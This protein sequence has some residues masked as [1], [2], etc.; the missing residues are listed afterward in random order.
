MGIPF[1]DDKEFAS[2]LET[3]S[4]QQFDIIVDAIFGFGFKALPREPFYGILKVILEYILWQFLARTK[5][6][7]VSIDV[8]SGWDV[9]KGF[10]GVKEEIRIDPTV[11]VSLSAPKLCAKYFFGAHYLGGR[12]IPP[13]LN[14]NFG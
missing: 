9:E 7:I 1:L 14:Q 13:F 12:F 10:S 11:L 2:A 3:D 4:D 5:V 8:P 6:P